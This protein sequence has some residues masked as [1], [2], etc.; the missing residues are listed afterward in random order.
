M[1]LLFTFIPCAFV[2]F[3]LGAELARMTSPRNRKTGASGVADVNP[4]SLCTVAA[5]AIKNGAASP[6]AFGLRG[7]SFF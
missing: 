3:G 4:S 7:A 6:P 2:L 5:I 1:P